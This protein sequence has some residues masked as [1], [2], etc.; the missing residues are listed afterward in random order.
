MVHLALRF[1]LRNPEFAGV[2]AA[3]RIQ[4]AVEMAAWA[5]EHGAASVSFMEHHGS[6]DGYLP[7]PI[8][9]A[10]AVA[11]RTS[12]TRI[13]INALLAPFYDPIRLAEDVAVL[14]NISG[15]RIDLLLGSGYV[16]E[17]F[18]LYGVSKSERGRRMTEVVETLRK[19]WTGQPFEYRGREVVVTPAPTRPGGPLLMM[20]GSS[21]VAARRAARIGDGFMPSNPDCWAAYREEMLELGKD[22]PGPGMMMG[23]I[24]TTVLA[25]DPDKAWSELAPY[26]LHDMNTYGTWLESNGMKGPYWTTTLEELPSTGAYRVITP[27]EMIEELRPMGEMAFAMLHPMVGGIPPEK[28]WESLRLLEEKVLPA[29]A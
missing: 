3:E 17:E 28:A 5:D 24:F 22:D 14:D 10:A 4:A 21:D 20:G 9:A 18:T 11:A 29:F 12:T 23:K 25:D 16:E 27:D 2:S 26:F 15:G 8:V 6:S 7:S 19:A 13:G 1:D